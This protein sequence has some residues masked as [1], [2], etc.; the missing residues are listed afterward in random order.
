MI[1][2]APEFGAGFYKMTAKEFLGVF[3]PAMRKM[4]EDERR[5]R[6]QK[7]RKRS[8]ER[9]ERYQTTLSLGNA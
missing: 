1:E 9:E 6:A 4:N 8:L 3:M 7:R 5:E 2:E